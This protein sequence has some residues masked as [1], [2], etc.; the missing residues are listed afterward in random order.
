MHYYSLTQ[1]LYNARV[2][3]Q[4]DIQYRT[5]TPAYPKTYE[6]LIFKVLHDRSAQKEEDKVKAFGAY[7]KSRDAQ[8]RIVIQ[9]QLIAVKEEDRKEGYA[10]HLM[11][12]EIDELLKAGAGKFWAM[13]KDSMTEAH[14]LYVKVAQLYPELEFVRRRATAAEVRNPNVKDVQVFELQKK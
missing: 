3:P 7:T 12:A 11:R 14:A 5:L 13:S 4:A 6:S 9:G 2:T 1:S 10:L 8:D